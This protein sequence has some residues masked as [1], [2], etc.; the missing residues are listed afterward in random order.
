MLKKIRKTIEKHWAV[1][2]FLSLYFTLLTKKIA[3]N[4]PPFFDWDESIYAQVGREMMRNVSLL[5]PYWQGRPW[6]DKPPVPNLFYGLV[7]LLPVQPEIS[8]RIATLALSTVVL[9]FLYKLSLRVTKSKAASLLAVIITAFLPVYFQRS[10]ALNV[11]VFLMIGW[12]GYV[13]WYDHFILST[14]FLVV[15]V[16]SKSLLGFFPALMFL[17]YH[18]YCLVRREISFA[19]FREY[20]G[21]ILLQSA[22]ASLWFIYMLARFGYPFIQFQFIDSHFKRVA[23]S[24]EQHF[25]QRTFYVTVLIDQF[26]LLLFPALISALYLTYAFFAKKKEKYLAFISLI[27]LPWFLFLNVT[28]TK[29]EWYIYPVL[30]QFA[31]LA[32]YPVSFVKRNTLLKSGLF[33]GLAALYF[34]TVTPVSMLFSQPF[35]TWEDHQLIALEAKK[36]DCSSLKVLVSGD[37]R[38]SYATLKSMD[39]VISTTTWWGNHPSIAYYSDTNTAYLYEVKQAQDIF[40]NPDRRECLIVESKDG[41]LLPPGE[42]MVRVPE[43]NPAYDLYQAP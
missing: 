39:L 42:R 20:A 31:L 4:P 24:I 17:L 18:G 2:A 19:V 43:T 26:K 7:G 23:S 5:V 41:I 12:L 33:A 14:V 30:T 27:F 36:R 28:K 40:R 13:L 29:I 21:K 3:A 35:S 38:T 9:A 25:G 22:A 34:F 15:A 16:L 1:I 37:T 32:A 11:D 6:L 8:T 10:I